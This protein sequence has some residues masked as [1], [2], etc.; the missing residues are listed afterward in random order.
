M[1]CSFLFLHMRML[2]LLHMVVNIAVR[3]VDNMCQQ[4]QQ[5]EMYMCSGGSRHSNKCRHM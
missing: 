2:L 3:F 4:Q 5:S 1:F